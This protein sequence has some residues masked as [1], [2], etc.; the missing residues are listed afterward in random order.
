MRPSSR[1]SARYSSFRFGGNALA[2]GMGPLRAFDFRLSTRSSD[3]DASTAAVR[4]P[5]RFRPSSGVVRGLPF[6]HSFRLRREEDAGSHRGG[7]VRSLQFLRRRSEGDAGS[8]RGGV[9]TGLP[10]LRRSGLQVNVIVM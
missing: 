4:E 1:L 6:V 10:F 7:V 5:V 3:S 8:R 2:S 9:V